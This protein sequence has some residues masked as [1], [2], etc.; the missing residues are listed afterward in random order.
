VL[1]IT[2]SDLIEAFGRYGPILGTMVIK[3]P[4]TN[5]SR[6]VGNDAS[7]VFRLLSYKCPLYARSGFAFVNFANFDDSERALRG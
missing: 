7:S 5:K 2:D 3:D 4:F 6:Y 1:Q